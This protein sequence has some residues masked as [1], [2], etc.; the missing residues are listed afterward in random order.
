VN[1]DDIV[2]IPASNLGRHV[3][4][5]YSDEETAL[6]RAIHLAFDLTG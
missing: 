3:G 6:T 5:L 2:T 4:F 1:C